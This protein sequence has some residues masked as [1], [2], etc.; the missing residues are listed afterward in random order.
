MQALKD[1]AEKY[2]WLTTLAEMLSWCLLI[3]TGI[4]DFVLWCMH[5]L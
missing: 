1:F 2:G 4:C 5:W 3:G